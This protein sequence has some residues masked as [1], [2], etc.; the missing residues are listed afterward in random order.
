MG[1]EIPV[2]YL[3]RL[4]CVF[5]RLTKLFFLIP[6]TDSLVVKEPVALLKANRVWGVLRGKIYVV[7]LLLSRKEMFPAGA[8]EKHSKTLLP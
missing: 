6:N 8:L 7:S 2:T 4:L 3:G 1:L 5:G